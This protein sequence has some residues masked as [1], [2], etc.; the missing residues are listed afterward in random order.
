MAGTRNT[1]VRTYNLF[2]DLTITN[3]VYDLPNP[4]EFVDPDGTPFLSTAI[5]FAAD[6][7]GDVYFSFDGVNDHGRV[8][9]NETLQMDHRR[10]R[11]VWFRKRTDNATMRFW[12]W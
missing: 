9:L 5:L 10:E 1:S 7:G 11:R 12:A 2:L 3:A 6:S 4:Y 8:V